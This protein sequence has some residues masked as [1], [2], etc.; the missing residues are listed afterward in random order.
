MKRLN[1]LKLNSLKES[2]CGDLAVNI[3]RKEFGLYP[4]SCQIPDNSVVVPSASTAEHRRRI[5]K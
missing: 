4:D 1:N 2:E 5:L 3:V